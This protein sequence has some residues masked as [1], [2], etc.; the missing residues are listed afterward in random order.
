MKR[1]LSRCTIQVEFVCVCERVISL[2]PR[3]AP[4]VCVCARI[5]IIRS[6]AGFAHP[7]SFY[8]DRVISKCVHMQERMIEGREAKK[9]RG[10]V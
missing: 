2:I 4:G 5:Y 8:L 6:V 10:G 7:H 3:L 9:E 1:L